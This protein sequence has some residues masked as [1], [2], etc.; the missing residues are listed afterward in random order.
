[1]TKKTIMFGLTALIFGGLVLAPK[2]VEAYRGDPSVTGPN[3]TVERH[4]AMEQA[5]ENKDYA[6]WKN[7]MQ[8]RGRVTQ[9]VTAQNF[10]KFVQAHE[11]AE[12]GK[13]AQANQIRQDL[14]LGFQR[15]R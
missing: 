7:L 2:A 6:A 14:G 13:F 11:L 9:V 3:Y 1:M 15:G 10:A 5:F 12:Q 8:G 4:A